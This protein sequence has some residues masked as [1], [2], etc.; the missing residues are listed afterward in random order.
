MYDIFIQQYQVVISINS[1]DYQ[2]FL[3]VYYEWFRTYVPGIRVYVYLWY[4]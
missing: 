4:S 1:T 2:Q 3:I